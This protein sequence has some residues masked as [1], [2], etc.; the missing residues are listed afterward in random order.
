[1]WEVREKLQHGSTVVETVQETAEAHAWS[2]TVPV[3]GA[4]GHRWL[5]ARTSLTMVRELLVERWSEPSR[6]PRRPRTWCC[7]WMPTTVPSSRAQAARNNTSLLRSGRRRPRSRCPRGGHHEDLASR[8]PTLEFWVRGQMRPYSSTQLAA[9][10][11]PTLD[12]LNRR[13][14][15]TLAITVD[16]GPSAWWRTKGGAC[17]R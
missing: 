13:L 6:R 10:P 8:T 14:E 16:S 9:L 15:P 7:R 5:G 4:T 17:S 1:M 2:Y 3:V 11:F 12:D